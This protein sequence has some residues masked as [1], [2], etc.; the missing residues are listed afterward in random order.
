VIGGISILL[1]SVEVFILVGVF[2]CAVGEIEF[3]WLIKLDDVYGVG[4]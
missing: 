4:G 1:F 2:D 3:V